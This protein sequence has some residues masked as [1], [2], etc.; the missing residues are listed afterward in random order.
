M[1]TT[2]WD[3]ILDRQMEC[4][5]K[6]PQYNS[7]LAVVLLPSLTLKVTTPKWEYQLSCAIIHNNDSIALDYEAN[8]Y[9]NMRTQARKYAMRV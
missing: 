9:Q 4:N 6:C 5:P 3:S 2:A 1:S 7:N 8:A